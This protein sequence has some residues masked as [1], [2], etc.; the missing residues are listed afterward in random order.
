ML[1]DWTDS[2]RVNELSVFA[3]RFFT[4]L[5]M[6]ADDYGCF[7]ANTKLIKSKLFPLL[8]DE[9]DEEEVLDWIREC[10]N[11]GLLQCYQVK[12]KEYIRI[13]EYN[14]RLRQKTHKYPMPIGSE[15]VKHET[16]TMQMPAPN[17]DIKPLPP[18]IESR[19]SILD[20]YFHDFPNS[21]HCENIA[22]ILKVE[23][24]VLVKALPAFRKAA[25]LSY[26]NGIK[27]AEHFKNWYLKQKSNSTLVP[28]KRNQI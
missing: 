15:E 4:R 20:A 26:P 19:Q 5:I 1:R 23:K 22:R 27:F 21:T 9:I 14:Q 2:E 7:T 3:E 12:G 16:I 25:N 24:A 8:I 6:K 18:E 17:M 10:K 28:K 11:V 13:L